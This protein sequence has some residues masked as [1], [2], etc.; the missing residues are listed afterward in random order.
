MNGVWERIEAALVARA[1]AAGKIDWRVSVDST[2]VRAHV[3]AAGARG[4]SV[5]RVEGEPD[6][7]AL[8]RSRGG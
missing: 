8:G 4:D 1:D 2:A 6:D 3:H 5:E 7:H